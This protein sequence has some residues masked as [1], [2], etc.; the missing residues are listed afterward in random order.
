MTRRFV[1]LSLLIILSGAFA[2]SLFYPRVT[3][4]EVSGNAHYE[5]AELLR[6]AKVK[7]G[8]PFF[9]VIRPRLKALAADPWILSAQVYRHWPDTVSLRVRERTPALSDGERAYALDGTALPGVSAAEQRAL[10]QVSGWGESRFEESLALLQQLADFGPKMVSYSP[11]GFTVQLATSHLFTPS[12]E[13]L[14]A[15]W[16]SFLSQQGTHAYVYPW[17]VSAAHE[18]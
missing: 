14:R 8:T 10:I 17:G 5:R 9:W 2:G 1:M 4:V 13:A 15:N 7:P 16:A 11:A 6:L 3:R 12:L 18:R